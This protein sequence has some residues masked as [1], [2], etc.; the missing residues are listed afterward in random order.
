MSKVSRRQ[1]LKVGGVAAATLAGSRSVSEAMEL[2]R[3]ERDYNYARVAALREPAYTISP[4]GK[5]K[6]PIEVFVEGGEKI[7]KGAGHPVHI[8]SIRSFRQPIQSFGLRS[9]GQF[10]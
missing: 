4:Y 5:L 7:V 6:S 3:G 8:A 1:F 9:S 2:E 10:S